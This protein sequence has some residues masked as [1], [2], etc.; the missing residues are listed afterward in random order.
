MAARKVQG[1]LSLDQLE[2]TGRWLDSN[3]FKD[4]GTQISVADAVLCVWALETLGK[5]VNSIVIKLTDILSSDLNMRLRVMVDLPQS[6]PESLLQLCRLVTMKN[7]GLA[8]EIANSTVEDAKRMQLPSGSII[9]NHTSLS[10]LLVNFAPEDSATK[11]AVQYTLKQLQEKHLDQLPRIQLS[12]LYLDSRVLWEAGILPKDA[13][14]R[15]VNAILARQASNGS[16]G[17]NSETIS[18]VRTLA[19]LDYYTAASAIQRGAAQLRNSLDR[20]GSLKDDLKDT[21]LFVVA[22]AEASR[23]SSKEKEFV[24]DT[25]VLRPSAGVTVGQML[26]AVLRRAQKSVV[27]VNFESEALGKVL[28]SMLKSNPSLAIAFV[29]SEKGTPQVLR[30]FPAAGNVRVRHLD[31]QIPPMLVLDDETVVYGILSDESL[32]RNGALCAVMRSQKLA[33]EILDSLGLS[34]PSAS[35]R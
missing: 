26:S 7:P 24:V 14:E 28:L 31:Y 22:L 18:A 20:D 12:D 17:K 5:D 11:Q 16:W 8:K 23:Q 2:N 21:A 27:A 33:K 25:G 3:L 19:M 32:G 13:S 4:L 35:Q 1:A 15:I 6:S 34:A 30:Q 9:G 29:H 10:L